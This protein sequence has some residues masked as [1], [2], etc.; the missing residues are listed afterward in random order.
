MCAGYLEVGTVV[1]KIGTKAI[2]YI[3]FNIQAY[4]AK[5]FVATFCRAKQD[6]PV[7][8]IRLWASFGV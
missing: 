6:P 7:T 8:E 5:I 2:R 1:H 3:I 4:P